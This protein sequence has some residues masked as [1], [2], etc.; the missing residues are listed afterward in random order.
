M[1]ADDMTEEEVAERNR[2]IADMVPTWM[3]NWDDYQV[4]LPERKRG[5]YRI[6]YREMT[7]QDFLLTNGAVTELE[8]LLR[9]VVVPGR[10]CIFA[11]LKLAQSGHMEWMPWM[12]DTQAEIHDHFKFFQQLGN[13][14]PDTSVL[15][16]GL[17]IGVAL[18]AAIRTP[19]VTRIDVVELNP[20][21][22]EFVGGY[23]E[24]MAKDL[25]K[26]LHIHE[27]DARTFIPRQVS[28][29]WWDLVWH[30]IWQNINPDNLPEMNSMFEMYDPWSGWQGFW[31]IEHS[32]LMEFVNTMFDKYEEGDSND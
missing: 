3:P 23:Y 6:E 29:V 26:E 2:L 5:K 22:I 15:I 16:T 18:Q 13:C 32:R 14:G 25:G 8:A 9:R 28:P 17:G 30:D 11:E 24:A 31:S 20:I 7:L 12:S 4:R 10:Y 27:S 1:S 21:V 19:N